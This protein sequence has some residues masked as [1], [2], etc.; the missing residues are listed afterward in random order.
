MLNAKLAYLLSTCHKFSDSFFSAMIKRHKNVATMHNFVLFVDLYEPD[1]S[2]EFMVKNV[3][4]FLN[5]SI[6]SLYFILYF[7]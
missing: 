5:P 2:N 4:L 7:H 6:T 1:S 3:F